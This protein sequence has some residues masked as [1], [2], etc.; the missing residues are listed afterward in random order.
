MWYMYIFVKVF[1][2]TNL[3]IWFSHFLI[4]QLKIFSW[5]IFLMFDSNFVQNDFL[6]GYRESIGLHKPMHT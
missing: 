5:F 3:F 2:K 6:Y 4:Q 1:F